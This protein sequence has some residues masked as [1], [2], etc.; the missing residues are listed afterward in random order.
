MQTSQTP[1]AQQAQQSLHMWKQPQPDWP[2]WVHTKLA[3]SGWG[4]N[5]VAVR[6][7]DDTLLLT[8]PT[9][10]LSDA[11]YVELA[12]LGRPRIVLASNHYHYLGIDE[13]AARYPGAHVICSE[14]AQPRLQ[15]KISRPLNSL[16]VVQEYLASETQLLGLAGTKNGEVW[17][18]LRKDDVYA[19]IVS[20]AF[21]NLP[22]HPSGLMGLATRLTHTAPGLQL[23]K[24]FRWFGIRDRSAYKHWF[25]REVRRATPA[26]LVPAHGEV[27][28]D[29][30]LARH[31]LTL[32][33]ARL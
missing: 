28:H 24:P 25:E 9:P 29:V 6:L 10:G 12:T 1:Q 17:I 15:K 27:F 22:K 11:A 8:S 30:E 14:T 32:V 3:P 20:D 2:I 23:G 33:H 13:F 26:L 31:L 4:W 7:R 5:T 18:E 19:W 21:F 16:N